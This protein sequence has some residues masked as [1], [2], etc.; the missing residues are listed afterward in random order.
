MPRLLC[1]DD[2][3]E[4]VSALQASLKREAYE[5]SAFTSQIAA[6]EAVAK[7]RP[8]VVLCDYRMPY[9][10]GLTVLERVR[11]IAPETIRLMISGIPDEKDVAAALKS[12]VLH[13]VIFKPW[14]KNELRD[15]IR[16]WF[17]FHHTRDPE[18][19]YSSEDEEESA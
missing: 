15:E 2:E 12:G 1:V 4:I 14:I 8:E 13:R 17:E 6:L 5:V 16:S 9:M 10:N 3:E 18:V 11:E 7:L 19:L